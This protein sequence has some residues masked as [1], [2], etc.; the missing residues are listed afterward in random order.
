VTLE[1]RLKKLEAILD[2]QAKALAHVEKADTPSEDSRLRQIQKEL[3]DLK[4][5]AQVTP[6]FSTRAQ[7][8]VVGTASSSG[9]LPADVEKSMREV[10]QG[11]PGASRRF[12]KS[13]LGVNN[14]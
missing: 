12:W 8:I 1:D 6:Q 2:S 14:G 10:L 11:L 13:L 4:R 5:A 7:P 3:S 9:I